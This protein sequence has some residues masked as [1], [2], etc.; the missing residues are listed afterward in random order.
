MTRM[1]SPSAGAKEVTLDGARVSAQRLFSV[2][3]L[4]SG[5]RCGLTYVVFPFFFPI[6]GIAPGIGPG[7]GIA[8]GLV[9][10]M[11][12]GLSIRRFW[13]YGHPWRKPI[14]VVHVAV[15]ALM[16]V[17]IVVDLRDLLG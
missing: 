15:I 6:L 17:L 13:R 4:V 5:I 11:A 12:N 10:I 16:L 9:A 2:S 7:L 3:M 8:V 1:A 14:T